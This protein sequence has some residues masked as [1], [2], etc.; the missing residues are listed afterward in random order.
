MLIKIPYIWHQKAQISSCNFPYRIES[1][2]L[3][4]REGEGRR[5]DERVARGVDH[6]NLRGGLLS[7]AVI[8]AYS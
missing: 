1:L 6:S 7:D 2:K 4:G 3:D 8:L 5:D